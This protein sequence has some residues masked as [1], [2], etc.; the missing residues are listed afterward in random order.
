MAVI[1]KLLKPYA[2]VDLSRGPFPRSTTAAFVAWNNALG[3]RLDTTLTLDQ[4]PEG[5]PVISF[6][7]EPG[8]LPGDRSELEFHYIVP[9]D[10]PTEEGVVA[11]LNALFK[12][13]TAFS[14]VGTALDVADRIDSVVLNLEA[15]R[16]NSTDQVIV[17]LRALSEI[18]RGVS[19]LADAEAKPDNP[20]EVVRKFLIMLGDLFEAVGTKR[21]AEVIIAGGVAGVL[22][23]I[24]WPAVTAFGLAA[25]AYKG[26]DVYMAAL[27]ALGNRPRIGRPKRAARRPHQDDPPQP[28][29]KILQFGK[30][31]TRSQT[32]RA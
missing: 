5:L 23:I 24:G 25:A 15:L 10:T 18:L 32:D 3:D 11:A 16:L 13:P 26:R 20:D 17:E 31:R 1:A 30:P 4:I 21:G 8:L 22:G 27:Q 12:L 7:K 2:S 19:E 14:K 29:E 6:G 28:R 9:P